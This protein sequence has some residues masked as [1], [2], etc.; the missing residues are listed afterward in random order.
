MNKYKFHVRFV[1]EN[2]KKFR[3]WDW[4]DWNL[5]SGSLYCF[6]CHQVALSEKVLAFY[7][8]SFDYVIKLMAFESDFFAFRNMGKLKNEKKV[9]WC[10]VTGHKNTVKFMFTILITIPSH[11][12]SWRIPRKRPKCMKKILIMKHVFMWNMGLEFLIKHKKVSS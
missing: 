12:A 2:S 5:F 9:N 7:L 8:L 10:D 6:Y 3:Y 11:L 4:R 1:I